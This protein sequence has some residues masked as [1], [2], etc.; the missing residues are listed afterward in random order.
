VRLVV[1]NN[2]QQGTA[3]FEAAIVVDEAQST[4]FVHEETHAGARC[5]DHLRKYLLADFR[6]YR[7]RFVILAKFASSR[8]TRARRFSLELLIIEVRF[9]AN[10]PAKKMRYE[11]L[12][13]RRLLMDHAWLFPAADNG[14]HDRRGRCHPLL[15]SG[16]TAFPEE[17]VR[18]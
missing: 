7:L 4:K 14:F 12:G 11:Q 2:I 9:D 13:E 3:N 16:Q 8:T 15:L 17:I 10:G 18:T 5:A 6:D 1:Q